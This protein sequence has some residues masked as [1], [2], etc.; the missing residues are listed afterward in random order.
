MHKHNENK[1]SKNKNV[2]F[3]LLRWRALFADQGGHLCARNYN[4]YRCKPNQPAS[5]AN[6]K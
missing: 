5:S 2:Y 6:R 3:V 4:V 1:P